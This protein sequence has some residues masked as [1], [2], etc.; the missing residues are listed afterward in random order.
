[1]PGLR[2]K[3]HTLNT[4]TP[5]SALKPNAWLCAE[6]VFFLALREERRRTSTSCATTS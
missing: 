6:S 3:D 4:G 2:V 1:M 5:A